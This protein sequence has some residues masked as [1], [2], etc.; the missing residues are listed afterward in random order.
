MAKATSRDSLQAY[1][2]LT[3]VV[4]GQPAI[5]RD[6]PLL[7]PLDDLLPGDDATG[8]PRNPE[9]I[10]MYAGTLQTDRRALLEQY[11]SWTWPARWSAWAAWAP[12]A[13]SCCCS[14]AT[15]QDP[16][17]LQVKEADRRSSR[18]TSARASTPTM[19]SGWLPGSG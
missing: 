6:P 3:E 16:L 10:D 14:A 13:G 15:T 7:V 2:K 4:D 18:S 5:M 9:A 11:R 17:L 8:S 19:D 12:A 1:A